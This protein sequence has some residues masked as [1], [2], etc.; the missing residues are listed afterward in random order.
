MDRKRRFA[1]LAVLVI[2]TLVAVAAAPACGGSDGPSAGDDND[3]IKAAACGGPSGN[4]GCAGGGV[5][6][7]NLQSDCRH[8]DGNFDVNPKCAGVCV[9]PDTT[10]PCTQAE[11]CG[12]GSNLTCVF[13]PRDHTKNCR[14]FGSCRGFCVPRQAGTGS[15]PAAKRGAQCG[16]KL[17]IRCESGLQ[18]VKPS[19][20]CPDCTGTCKD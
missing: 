16:G 11:G 3:L 10:R 5:C 8:F 20:P 18:C 12:E 19:S 13:D 14:E 15:P 17:G 4:P 6:I 2:L 9:N 1:E 7:D